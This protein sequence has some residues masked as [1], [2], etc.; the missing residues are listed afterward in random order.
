MVFSGTYDMYIPIWSEQFYLWTFK[1]KLKLF[2]QNLYI[3][4]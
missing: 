4:R 1:E 3:M 2:D